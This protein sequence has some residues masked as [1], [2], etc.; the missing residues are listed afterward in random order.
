[1]LNL[2]NK[3]GIERYGLFTTKTRRTQSKKEVNRSLEAKNCEH[4][5]DDSVK[6]IYIENIL[7]E[8]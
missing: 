5:I 8:N 3:S 1:M 4:G 7:N 6:N 2:F